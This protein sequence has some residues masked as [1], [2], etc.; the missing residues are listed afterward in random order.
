MCCAL[1]GRHYTL[2]LL[3]PGSATVAFVKSV[4]SAAPSV[5]NEL[6]RGLQYGSFLYASR[7]SKASRPRANTASASIDDKLRFLARSVC[8]H[9]LNGRVGVQLRC[10]DHVLIG[11]CYKE[12]KGRWRSCIVAG[13]VGA[14]IGGS[15]ESYDNSLLVLVYF[16]ANLLECFNCVIAGSGAKALC[17]VGSNTIEA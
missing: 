10:G 16:C 15:Q 2:C 3:K 13:D 1:R 11:G 9:R 14:Q 4:G 7:A 8:Q 6:T 12:R 17:L 5:L